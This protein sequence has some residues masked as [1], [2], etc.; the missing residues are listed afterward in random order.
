MHS[1][2][3]IDKS[4]QNVFGKQSEYNY[5]IYTNQYCFNMHEI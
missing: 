1:T 3:G 4:N 2:S 5:H